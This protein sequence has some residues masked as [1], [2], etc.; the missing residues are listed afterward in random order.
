MMKSVLWRMPVGCLLDGRGELKERLMFR[1][2][3][4]FY[5]KDTSELK[6]H[7]SIKDQ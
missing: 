6:S 2:K 3:R 4:S 7:M 5:M 1:G